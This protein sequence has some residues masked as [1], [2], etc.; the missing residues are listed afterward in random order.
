ML[1]TTP[2]SVGVLH[3]VLMS[4]NVSERRGFLVPHHK[5]AIR[6]LRGCAKRSNRGQ[7]N[8]RCLSWFACRA[9][10]GSRST[11]SSAR[12]RLWVPRYIGVTLPTSKD[13]CPARC[14]PEVRR[15]LR[16]R[17]SA[18]VRPWVP[19]QHATIRNRY[20]SRMTGSRHITG[21]SVKSLLSHYGR[22]P[23]P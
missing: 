23:Q 7:R 21:Q 1:A 14:G 12:D 19:S 17:K 2:V 6:L 8:S 15:Q 20:H 3:S 4:L 18:G 16:Q 9:D 10:S 13:K 11:Y 5:A 22:E